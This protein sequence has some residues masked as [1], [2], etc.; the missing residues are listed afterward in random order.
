MILINKA[1]T[2]KETATGIASPFQALLNFYSAFNNQ[3]LE[4]ME[5]NWLQTDDA[6]MS[7]PLGGI[8]RGWDEIREVYKKIFNGEARVYV[9]FYD[10]SIHPTKDM[11]IAVG[12]ERGLLE[13]NNQQI[14]L[15]I[16][17]S[18]IYQLHDRQWKQ[19]HH[20]GSMDNPGLLKTY[21]A[22]LLNNHQE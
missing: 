3:N 4:S 9:E 7:N 19:I 22:T 15:A 11:F 10:Y 16:R 14:E 2:G 17:T 5:R 20:H 12:H 1:I 13:I 21:Q 6:S 8:K 18:R